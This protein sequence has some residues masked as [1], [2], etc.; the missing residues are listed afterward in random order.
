MAEHT[1][2]L[3]AVALA[4][5]EYGILI[6]GASGA[7]KSTLAARMISTWSN[8][9]VCLVADDRVILTAN[10]GR[11]V[12]RPHPAIAR[13]IE[14]HGLGLATYPAL[15]AVVIRLIIDLVAQKPVRMPDPAQLEADLL[16]QRLP[17]IVLQAHADPVGILRAFWS[18]ICNDLMP[19]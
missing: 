18:H 10:G 1:L 7:G 2:S 19:F 8:P 14:L 16:G 15:D 11:I 4:V 13:Q 3:H 12:A 9:A 17:R 6:R 5:G